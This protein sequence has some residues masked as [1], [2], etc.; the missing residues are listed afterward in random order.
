MSDTKQKDF[1]CQY[2]REDVVKL[3]GKIEASCRKVDEHTK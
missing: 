1:E 2:I 3:G